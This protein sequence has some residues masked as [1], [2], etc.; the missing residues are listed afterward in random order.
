MEFHNQKALQQNASASGNNNNNNNTDNNSKN[1]KRRMMDSTT[2]DG[3]NGSN[4]NMA[5][6]QSTYSTAT[7][8]T[9]SQAQDFGDDRDNI[10]LGSFFR[11]TQMETPS[12]NLF[13]KQT[14]GF[15]PDSSKSDPNAAARIKK[16]NLSKRGGGTHIPT[17]HESSFSSLLNNNEELTTS[18]L[19]G[20]LIS[21]RS[22]LPSGSNGMSSYSTADQTGDYPSSTTTT[23]TSNMNFDME[24]IDRL[25]YK[26]PANRNTA[27]H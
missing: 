16:I 23:R 2:N 10:Q 21:L 25:F 18:K 3:G 5:Y 8:T 27:D 14:P 22:S 12:Y 9:S 6:E 7:P 11:S 13:S 24:V 1:A 19:V 15:L 20:D 26:H 17:Q 4:Y